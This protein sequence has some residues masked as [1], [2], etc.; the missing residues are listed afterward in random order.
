MTRSIALIG[1][2]GSVGR[3]ILMILAEQELAAPEEMVVLGSDRSIGQEVSFGEDDLLKVTPLEGFDFTGIRTAFFA[4][5]AATARKYA[6]KAAAAGAVVI[7]CS[8]AFRLEPGVPLVVPEVNAAALEQA[9]KGIIAN[10]SPLAIMLAATL[11]PLHDAARAKRAVVTALQPVSGAGR[12]AMDELF[13]QTRAIYVNDPVK[14]EEFPK[15]ISFNLIPQVGSFQK[16]G[17]T[18]EEAALSGEARKLID[19]DLALTATCI[20]VP[21][22]IGQSASVTVEF[23]TALTVEAARDHL[24]RAGLTLIDHRADGGYAT[25]VEAAGDDPIFVSRLRE[26]KSVP[27]GL[28]FWCVTDNLRKGAALNAVQIFEALQARRQKA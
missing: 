13:T 6:P 4:A 12:A 24:R 2:T 16:N 23:E 19:P 28:S 15:Q 18:E 21:V 5:D 1:A 9:R 26:D 3:E 7:D 10:P 27:H 11:R 22:F 14:P 8:A 17:E 20:R 25:P